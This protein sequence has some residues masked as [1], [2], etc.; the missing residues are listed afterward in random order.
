MRYSHNLNP[1]QKSQITIS[2]W[3]KKGTEPIQIFTTESQMSFGWSLKK[4]NSP[5]RNH[6]C[7]LKQSIIFSVTI[8]AMLTCPMGKEP[9]F[10][11]GP[12]N[13]P[14][15]RVTFHFGTANNLWKTAQL[16]YIEVLFFFKPQT[17]WLWKICNP[18][19]HSYFLF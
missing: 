9:Q 8:Q 15:F 16:K 11:F 6:S 3:K 7:M 12:F 18:F 14:Y 5:P 19:E 13:C 4:E 1:I 17:Q 10:L 2:K